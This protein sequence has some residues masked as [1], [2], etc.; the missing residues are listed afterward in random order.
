[1]A[2]VPKPSVP[3]PSLDEEQRALL[4]AVV[5][6]V[7]AS[8]AM[9]QGRVA[10][11]ETRVALLSMFQARRPAQAKEIDAYLME[12][13]G[14]DSPRVQTFAETMATHMAQLL[15]ENFT[16]EE[17]LEFESFQ[18]TDEFQEMAGEFAAELQR[19]LRAFQDALIRDTNE[20]FR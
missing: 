5:D 9:E 11:E 3:I 7:R 8:Q 2:T 19:P 20:R 4:S 12:Q 1:M 17:L 14:P 10:A 18:L 6:V 15:V 16:L 13:A